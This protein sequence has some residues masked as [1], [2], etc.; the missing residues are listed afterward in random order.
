MYYLFGAGSFCTSVIG[1][2]GKQNVIA[3]VDNDV[4]KAGTYIKNK[5]I[6]TYS[7][8]IRQYKGEKIIITVQ[9]ATDEIVQMLNKDGITNYSVFPFIQTSLYTAEEI[10]EKWNLKKYK[11]IVTW[12]NPVLSQIIGEQL[13]EC[14]VI[15]LEN[16]K[17][18]DFINE[19]IFLLDEVSGEKCHFKNYVD[20]WTE[21]QKQKQQQYER[22]A[23]FKNKYAGK[24]CFLIGNGP[25]LTPEDL[26]KLYQNKELSFA[27]NRIY[28]IYDKTNW[29]PDFYFLIDG[30]TYEHNKGWIKRKGQI[31]F[32]KDYI[33]IEADITDDNVFLL[34]N[35]DFRFYPDF[36]PFSEDITKTFYG[37]RTT[38]YQMLQAAAYMG[39]KKIY[40][41]GVDFSWGEDGRGAHFDEN[42][43][44]KDTYV[45]ASKHKNELEHAY[46]AA[47]RFAETHNIKIYNAT[48]GGHLEVFERVD[49]DDIFKN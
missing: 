7:E 27:C 21:M 10:I 45:I 39:F 3:V 46:I 31:S 25:S 48:R 38:M 2:C 22:L 47:K 33:G 18:E 43:G 26:E 24:R 9:L 4:S 37:G 6:I 36:P 28:L 35:R 16:V 11:Q 29:R 40:L 41:L 44:N 14:R 8:L 32:V 34:R 5:K 12:G 30:Y 42:Y 20:I 49:F 13:H 19:I 23:V 17:T 15:Q 1:F